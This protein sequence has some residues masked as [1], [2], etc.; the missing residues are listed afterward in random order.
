MRPTQTSSPFSL[1]LAPGALGGTFPRPTQC[2]F[3]LLVPSKGL[4]D[5]L[6]CYIILQDKFPSG[7]PIVTLIY[8]APEPCPPPFYWSIIV[9][10][11]CL[12]GICVLR[13]LGIHGRKS[14]WPLFLFLLASEDL[15]CPTP[16]LLKEFFHSDLSGS[17]ILSFS[18]FLTCHRK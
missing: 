14:S 12:L 15:L 6:P 13:V 11:I 17:S 8:L 2:Q 1:S 9:Q 16:A 7:W 5:S 3:S 4:L 18:S 10:S